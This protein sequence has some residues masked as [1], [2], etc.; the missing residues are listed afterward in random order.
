M[1]INKL[2][3]TT[4]TFK[5]S[6]EYIPKEYKDVAASMEKQFIEHMLEQMEKTTGK[7]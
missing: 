4:S 5:K 6:A 2:V 1:D 7:R 3:P